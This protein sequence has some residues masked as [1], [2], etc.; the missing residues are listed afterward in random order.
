M[1][2]KLMQIG[3]LAER[4][5]VSHRTVHYYERIGLLRPAER[6]GGG[7]RYYDEVSLKRLGKI[8]QLK[9]LGLSLDEIADVIDLYFEDQTGSKGK[10]KVLEILRRHLAETDTRQ[11]ELIKF[12]EELVANI[13]MVEARLA[14]AKKSR[15]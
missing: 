11:A 3:Q 7:Y 9:K 8:A 6:E 15:I 4:A 12:R 10:I 1:A 13:A 5:G 14:A 2:P